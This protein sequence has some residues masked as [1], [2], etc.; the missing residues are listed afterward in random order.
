MDDTEPV[1]A[2]GVIVAANVIVC[3][4]T[5]VAGVTL[6]SVVVVET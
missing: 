1:A 4:K 6:L 3:R 2:A 5:G